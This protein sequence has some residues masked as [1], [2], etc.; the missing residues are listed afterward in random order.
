[1]V[2]TPEVFT[3]NSPISPRTSTPVK[4]PSAQ[5]SLCMFTNVLKG[6]KTAYCQVG[7]AKSK[8]K[9]IKFGNKP[10]ALKKK[11][12]G[13]SKIDEQIK[14]SPYDWIMH[15]PEVVQSPIVNDCMK[16]RIDCHTEPQLFPKLLLQVSVR[17]IHN[18]IVS[19]IKYGGIKES[20]DEDDNIIIS[21]STLR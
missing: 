17:E 8:R 3:D 4:K 16:V 14:K 1:M 21:D 11:R 7:A 6:K 13:N 18:N 5:K 20:R 9:A 19:A 15:H 2:Y 12:K 10:W